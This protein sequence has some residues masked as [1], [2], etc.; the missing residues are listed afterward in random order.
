MKKTILIF[1]LSSLICGCL[2]PLG[3]KQPTKTIYVLGDQIKFSESSLKKIP[4][5]IWITKT[6][7][8]SLIDSRKILFS[9][10]TSS[11]GEYQLASWAEPPP[12]RFTELLEQAFTNS[13]AFKA[14]FVGSNL[15]QADV[16]LDTKILEFYHDAAI[17]PPLVRVQVSAIL[18]TL[19]SRNVIAKNTFEKN[20]VIEENNVQGAVA[21]FDRAIEEIIN[22]ILIWS[23]VQK[24]H[25]ANSKNDA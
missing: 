6:E 15:A 11:R 24:N 16:A 7:S 10:E 3:N 4:I 5:R 13:Q 14:V 12:T 1:F 21:G 25:S 9:R 19:Q 23:T 17:T 8:S 20:L 2:L 22:E 18:L